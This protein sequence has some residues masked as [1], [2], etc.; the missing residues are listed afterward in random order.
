M[1]AASM[2]VWFGEGR[3]VVARS[4]GRL[5]ARFADRRLIPTRKVCEVIS[6]LEEESWRLIATRGSHR[7]YKAAD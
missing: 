3:D 1:A 6:T 5:R 7:Y 2:G 4:I